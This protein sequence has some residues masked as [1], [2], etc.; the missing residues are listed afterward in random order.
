[1]PPPVRIQFIKKNKQR[2]LDL[3]LGA[4]DQSNPSVAVAAASDLACAPAT[5][6]LLAACSAPTSGSP[7]P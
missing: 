6:D 1:M 5:G 7:P 4:L 3:G 2:S